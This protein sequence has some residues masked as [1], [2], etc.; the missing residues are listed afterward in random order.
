MKQVKIIK[1]GQV[2]QMAKFDD[3]QKLNDWKLML[4]TTHAWGKPQREEIG[5]NGL[6]TGVILPSEY[7][8]QV[9]DITIQEN[10]AKSARE[11]KHQDAKDAMEYLKALTPGSITTIAQVKPVLFEIIKILKKLQD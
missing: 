11:Q 6:P 10:D 3:D 8:F 9:E 5:E 7:E 1:S 2:V 4:E